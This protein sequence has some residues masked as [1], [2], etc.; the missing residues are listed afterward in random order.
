MRGDGARMNIEV[1]SENSYARK[2]V[3]TVPATDVRSEL[4]R[5]YRAY[6]QRARLPGFR[7]G[8]VPRKVLEARFG[9]GIAAEVAEQL[10]QK[11][12]RAALQDHGIEPVGQPALTDRGDVVASAD[13][14]FTI[15]VEVKPEVTVAVYKGLKAQW[16]DFAIP[17]EMVETSIA[18]RLRGQARLG[19]VE[20]RPVEAGDTVQVELKVMDGDA[21]VLDEP[22]TLVRT[23]GEA[24]LKG[25]ESFLLGLSLEES[26]SGEVTFADDARNTDVAGR[27]L[28]VSAKVLSIQAMKV[29]E[30]DKAIAE[31][32][33]HDSVDA[34]RAAVRKELEAGRDEQAR[35]QARANLLQALIDANP[36]DV[37]NG[38]VE[39]NLELLKQELR[40]QAAYRGQDPRT[41]QFSDEQLVD[42]RQRATF[43]SRGALLL[44]SV[45]TS[46]GLE[47]TD[48][49]VDARIAEMAEQRGQTSQQIKAWLTQ[50]GG[51]EEFRQRILEEKTLDWL[52]GHAEIEKV[53]PSVA[54]AAAVEA[55][56]E[57]VEA[58]P[59]KAKK[60]AKKAE[61]AAPEAAAAP[62][63]GADLSVL[64]GAIKDVKDALATGAYDAHL[65]ALL[66]AEESGRNRKGAVS[67][68]KARMG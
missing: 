28:A 9:P 3:V 45:W 37:P 48:E 60:A 11:G 29:P 56:S 63:G 58:A 46:E 22:G 54:A 36:I 50:D 41:V 31:E 2:V 17:D 14:T 8:R 62:A 21:V 68:I 15:A 67:A 13:F 51:L 42:L 12:W 55:A 35:N 20:G 44:E 49:D 53:D 1:V 30:L 34:F 18:N 59:K 64:D 26:K 61:E 32:L 6:E 24:W 25:L 65:D 23:A 39:Q 16:P 19:V 27:T 7:R 47:A 52:L 4:D 38:M 43:A 33:G 57:P 40:Y 10:V 66:A 5:A